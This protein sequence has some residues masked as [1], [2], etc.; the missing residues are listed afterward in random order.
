MSQEIEIEFKQRIDE[1]TFDKLLHHFEDRR[2]PLFTQVNHYFETDGYMLKSYHSALRVRE[3]DQ[4]FVLTLK[5]PYGQGLLETHQSLSMNDFAHLKNTG[6]L[7]DGDVKNQ[8]ESLTGADAFPLVYFGSLTTKRSEIQ[9]P[10]GLLVLDR[11]NYLQQTD[12]EMEFESQSF[13][14]GEAFFDYL[15]KHFDLKREI[16]DN[17]IRRFFKALENKGVKTDD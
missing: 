9:L 10:E 14:E 7:P 12:Y 11:S 16:P 13:D 5:Q 6:Q 8:I 1:S 17:K 4:K 15:V 2:T 3:K